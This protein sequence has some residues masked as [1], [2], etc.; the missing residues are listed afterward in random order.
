MDLEELLCR[1]GRKNNKGNYK[2][3]IGNYKL[4]SISRGE[5]RRARSFK[6]SLW[7]LCFLAHFVSLISWRDDRKR[8]ARRF[9][10]SLWPLCFFAGFV[11]LISRGDDGES[12]ERGVLI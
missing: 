1:L 8:R 3:K 5:K 9:E 10:N 11:S 6:N 7:P 2:F 4:R 12:K